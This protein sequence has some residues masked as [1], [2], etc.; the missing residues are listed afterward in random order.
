MLDNRYALL[1]IRTERPLMDE[2][3]DILR[4]PNVSGTTDGKAEPFRH[5]I[6]TGSVATLVFDRSIDP[7]KLPKVPISESNYELLTE[8]DLEELFKQEEKIPNEKKQ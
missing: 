8:E 1:F 3:F 5:G 7:A 4:H 6:S 2:K